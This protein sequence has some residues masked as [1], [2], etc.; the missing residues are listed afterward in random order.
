MPFFLVF[1]MIRPEIEPQS[2]EPLSKYKNLMIIKA[3]IVTR[4]ILRLIFLR[5]L[6]NCKKENVNEIN[7]QVTKLQKIIDIIKTESKVL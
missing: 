5:K 4:K 2:P 3:I 7:S 1:G 6:I